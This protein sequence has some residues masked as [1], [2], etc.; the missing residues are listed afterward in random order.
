MPNT[1][2]HTYETASWEKDET[3]HW[4]KSTC[5]ATDPAH[6]GLK[7]DFAEHAYGAWTVKTPAEF[8]KNR[9]IIDYALFVDL[10]TQKKFLNLWNTHGNINMTIKITGKKQLVQ[11]MTKL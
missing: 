7:N 4:H 10:K 6:Q 9:V 2:T 5:D 8:H 11:A 3:G 1:A